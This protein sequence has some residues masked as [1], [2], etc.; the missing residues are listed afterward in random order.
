MALA[1]EGLRLIVGAMTHEALLGD[2]IRSVRSPG[3]VGLDLAWERLDSLTK[4]P[5]SLGRLEEIAARM[6]SIQESIRPDASEKV[7]VL[8]AG[9]H[10]VVAEGISPYPQEV[11][12][13][14]VANFGSGGAA[15]NQMAESAGA[16]LL[17][18]DAGV[19]GDVSH[20]A[21]VRQEKIVQ[22]TQNMA[23]GPA[24]SREDTAR[25]VLLGIA[26]AEE[27]VGEGARLIGTGE[28]GIGN[29]T[30]ASAL[31]AA[32]TGADPSDVVGAGTG[33][34]AEGVA[35]K[36]A[37]VVRALTVNADLLTDPLGVLSAVGGAEIATLAGVVIGASSQGTAVVAD[38]FI[39][40]AA[41]LAAVRLAPECREYLF[42]SHLS[43][44]PG[45]RALLDALD[46]EPVLD[47]D[48]RLGEGTGAALC[49][50]IVDAACCMMS[51]MATF[52][53]AGVSG[54]SEG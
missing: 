43:V 14:M 19:S 45:H 25:A 12:W 47:L 13:Q 40:G 36:R 41:A 23:V 48:M 7:I 20:L 2:K 37:V 54:E 1:R 24:M 33:L 34:D 6:A 26:L 44:E 29:T 9:D 22:G 30:A 16:R 18:V 32:Y 15:I 38:G 35:H 53:E 3:G 5:R 28:M 46:L 21:A 27:V 4:P 49:M 11:T 51:G 52:A 8:A 39:S 17:L 42:A 31:T 10:G 50:S